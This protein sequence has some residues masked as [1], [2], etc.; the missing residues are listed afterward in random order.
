MP[1]N[2]NRLKERGK[3]NEWLEYTKKYQKAKYFPVN[4]KF[5]KE[6]DKDVCEFLAKCSAQRKMGQVVRQ[7][8]REY[9]HA[10]KN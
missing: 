7:I 5:D 10:H 1:M 2:Y 4:I 9:V 8:I 6:T 3:Y